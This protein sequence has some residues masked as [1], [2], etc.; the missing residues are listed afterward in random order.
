LPIIFQKH[1]CDYLFSYFSPQ[2]L[3]TFFFHF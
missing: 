1:T 2:A 3:P